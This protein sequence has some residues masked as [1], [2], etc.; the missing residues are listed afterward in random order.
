MRHK[1]QLQNTSMSIKDKI[2]NKKSLQ[3]DIEH[4]VKKT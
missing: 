2:R 4:T 3:Y 1:N